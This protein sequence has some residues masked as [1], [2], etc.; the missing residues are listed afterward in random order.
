M[1]SPEGQGVCQDHDVAR[2]LVGTDD[3]LREFDSGGGAG[4]VSH[5]GRAVT[6]LGPEYPDVWAI[7]NGTEVQRS[8]KGGWS[9]RGA[10]NGLTANCIADTRA[11]YLVGTSEA[12]LYR[13]GDDGLQ[14][15]EAFDRVEGREA[16]YTP[17]G[18]PPDARS[19]SEDGR[20][21]YVNVHVGGIVRTTDEG[22]TW[23]PTI[24]ID[25]DVHRVWASDER[26]FAACARG[27]AVSEDRG[28]SWDMR[29]EGLH[30][31]Y[32]RGVALCGESVLVSASTGP[33]GGRS[34]VYRGR[35]EGGPFERCR[36]GLPEWFDR[37]IDSACLDAMP[38]GRLAAFGT[39]DGRVFA[40]NDQG[41]TWGE[42]AAGLP[43]IRCVLVM[44]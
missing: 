6:A 34:A 39:E 19:I 29:T 12:G 37:N 36:E 43:V 14:R 2:I 23:E 20:T 9:R 3:G 26:V 35:P 38:D 32:S 16:W 8:G 1:A 18:G 15:V 25:A 10:L 44:P 31:T 7:L 27:L 4:P 11:G 30:A 13:V 17:W 5:E 41:A 33:R 42:V 28:G 40:S 21:V 22:A 24:D